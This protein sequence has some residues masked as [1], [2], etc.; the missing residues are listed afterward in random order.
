[1]SLI[2]EEIGLLKDENRNKNKEIAHLQDENQNQNQAIALLKDENQNQNKEISTSTKAN[3]VRK[4]E[5]QHGRYS[6]K[7]IFRTTDQLCRS[8]Q[9]GLH[10]EWLLPGPTTSNF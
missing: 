7:T 8:N 1:L 2:Y 10:F 6:S 4:K 5:E 9:V 3:L